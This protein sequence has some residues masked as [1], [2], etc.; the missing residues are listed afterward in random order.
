MGK[1]MISAVII[2][3]NEEKNIKI[4]IES[5]KWC[6]EVLVIDD[7][8]TDKTKEIAE[9]ASAKVF[10]RDMQNDFSSQRNFALEKTKGEWVLFIDA[11]ERISHSLQYEIIQLVS[12]PF[13]DVNGYFM[14][15]SDH[16]WGRKIRFGETASIKLLRLGKK[17][18]G[19]WKGRV[20]ERWI[21]S[22]KKELLMNS[23]DHYPHP[24]IKEFLSEINHYSTLR[25][26]ELFA[27]KVKVSML[28]IVVFPKA[29]FIHNYFFRLG[30]FDGVP[31]VV[32]AGMMSFHS[33]LVRGKL[34]LLYHQKN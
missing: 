27:K 17:G 32:I 18:K 5:L 9:K 28:G 25:S 11:D 15:R 7:N 29:K 6:D 24:S 4:C 13:N 20:H 34:W 33:F 19:E 22:G 14:K 30:I 10:T 21:V 23:L 31:G 26:Q 3:K 2:A 1:F 16:M 8:S 12:R